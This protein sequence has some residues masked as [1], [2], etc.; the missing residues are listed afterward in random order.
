MSWYDYIK[1]MINISLLVF[2]LLNLTNTVNFCIIFYN[3]SLIC[4]NKIH[5]FKVVFLHI[6]MMS[7]SLYFKCIS[8]YLV[9]D[10]IFY[11]TLNYKKTQKIYRK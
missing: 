2:I 10:E 8:Y 11:F 1:N 9:F 7:R 6:S 4:S 5:E 3:Y